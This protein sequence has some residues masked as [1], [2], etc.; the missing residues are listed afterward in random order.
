[1]KQSSITILCMHHFYLLPNSSILI[2]FVASFC[3]LITFQESLN[4]LVFCDIFDKF[5][6]IKFILHVNVILSLTPILIRK[7]PAEAS[8]QAAN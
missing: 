8:T 5:S 2:V 4:Y 7:F 1:M 6:F 3:N